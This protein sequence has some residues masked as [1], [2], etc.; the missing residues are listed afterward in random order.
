MFEID[1]WT[2]RMCADFA[3][4]FSDMALDYDMPSNTP[5]ILICMTPRS[6][7]S[8]FASLFEQNGLG[9]ADEHFRL[10]G[11]AM[12]KIVDDNKLNTFGDFFNY[13]C[14]TKKG[15]A[16]TVK[17]DW[18]QFRPIYHFGAFHKYFRDSAF[19]FLRRRDVVAQAVSHTIMDMTGYGDT[20]Q[21]RK[22]HRFAD[23]KPDVA[24]ISKKLR[25]ILD[26]D[27]AWQT[28]FA[29]ENIQPLEIYY[30]DIQKDP[31][32]VLKK[33]CHYA[34][35]DLKDPVQ[36]AT[37]FRP[38]KT[39]LNDQFKQSFLESMDVSR[40]SYLAALSKGEGYL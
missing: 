4:T 10:A 15:A 37:A 24:L 12:Q 8:Y 20:T 23:L 35:V 25:F 11:Q 21:D 26:I 31:A 5:K 29:V 19:I 6:G 30:E 39:P 28:F 18:I 3:A 14:Q 1:D 38:V 17:T 34:G 2:R 40:R 13:L 16:L 22:D 27:A 33:T 7:S 9:V 32:A 36:T